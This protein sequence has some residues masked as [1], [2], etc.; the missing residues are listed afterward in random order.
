[1]KCRECVNARRYRADA[2]KCIVYGMVINE[3]HE[4]E[5]KGRKRRHEEDHGQ[6]GGAGADKTEI[7]DAGG[8]A[9]GWVPRVL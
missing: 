1:M 5:R 4:C 6:R 7:R 3:N 2:V 9:A 8:G